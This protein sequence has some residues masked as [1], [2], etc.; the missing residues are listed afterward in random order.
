MGKKL[1]LFN[2]FVLIFNIIIMLKSY[3]LFFVIFSLTVLFNSKIVQRINDNNDKVKAYI[4]S[5]YILEF[6]IFIYIV[7]VL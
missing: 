1:I 7:N 3:G 4:A 2:I 6:L 5:M